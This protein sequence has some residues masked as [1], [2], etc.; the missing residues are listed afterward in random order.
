MPYFSWRGSFLVVGGVGLTLGIIGIIF[1]KEPKRGRFDVGMGDK[2]KV[3]GKNLIKNYINGFI[4]IFRNPC[5]RWII[6]AGCSRFWAGNAVAYYTA[7]YFN[8][9]P[10]NVVS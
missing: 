2:P 1:I 8:I 6:F 5:S 3:T 10:D 7:K 9:F 4:E